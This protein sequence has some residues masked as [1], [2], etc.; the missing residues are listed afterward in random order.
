LY[1]FIIL[2]WDSERMLVKVPSSF[3]NF[4]PAENLIIVWIELWNEIGPL[5]VHYACAWLVLILIDEARAIVV[6]LIEDIRGVVFPLIIL[7]VVSVKLVL[8]LF[9]GLFDWLIRLNWL[10]GL[11]RLGGGGGSLFG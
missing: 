4:L 7:V 9:N 2:S 10:S 8:N 5:R 6:T 11:V 1:A 3:E